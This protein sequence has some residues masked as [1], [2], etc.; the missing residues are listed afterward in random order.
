MQRQKCIVSYD[1][2]DSIR[3]MYDG[4]RS[5]IYSIGYS[6]REARMGSEVMFFCKT[7]KVPPLAG[8]MKSIRKR[9]A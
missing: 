4:C 5:I 3:D 2:V 6:A 1:N 8:A 9:T 7:L